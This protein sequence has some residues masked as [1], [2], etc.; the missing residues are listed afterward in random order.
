[1]AVY[2]REQL[3]PGVALRALV[4]EATASLIAMD[5]EKLED[6]ALC[7]ADLNRELRQSGQGSDAALAERE[8]RRDIDLLRRVLYETRANLLV[9]SRLH[10]IHIRGA[11]ID[12]AGRPPEYGGWNRGGREGEYGDN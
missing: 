7:C 9:I 1:M 2:W 12:N 8:T 5:A 4:Q 11:G 10:A 3:R 6:L